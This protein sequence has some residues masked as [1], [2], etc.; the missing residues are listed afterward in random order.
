MP[1]IDQL[2]KHLPVNCGKFY[3]C[4]FAQKLTELA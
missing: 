2:N 1:I 3:V 4:S